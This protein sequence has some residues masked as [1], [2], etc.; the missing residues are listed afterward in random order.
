MATYKYDKTTGKLTKIAGGTLYADSPVGSILPFGGT[1]I[2]T[3]WLACSGQAISRTDYADLYAVIGTYY[4]SGD[5]STTFN[6]PDLREATVKGTGL[7]GKSNA[8]YSVGGITLGQFVDDQMQG[9]WHDVV[10]R[11]SGGS[12]VY[13]ADENLDNYNSNNLF[14]TKTRN[15][16]TDP[17]SDG[18]N[19]TPRTG[20]TT[21]VKAVGVNFII[22][23]KS[24]G[25]PADI[26]N[27]VES[28]VSTE[29]VSLLKTYTYPAN[30]TAIGKIFTGNTIRGY[31]K[32]DV[33]LYPNG[34]ARVD[35][36]IEITTSYAANEFGYG[37]SPDALHTINSNIPLITPI[38]P[39]PKGNYLWLINGASGI[40]KRNNLGFSSAHGRV[41]Y[42]GKLYWQLGRIYNTSA[43][44]GGWPTS[45]FAVGDYITGTCWGTFSV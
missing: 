16:A 20:T 17:I 38:T 13:V 24:V 33:T 29:T 14:G 34:I 30:Y 40:I 39:D 3:G 19:G 35:Y 23:A 21:E 43:T 8:H 2:P 32:A 36:A 41:N 6:V 4:G 15:V 28:I 7:S 42:N 11:Q 44:Y 26:T 25:L 12:K 27:E 10:L 31:G 18:T 9:H 45:E 5:G 1:A 22:K 37:I